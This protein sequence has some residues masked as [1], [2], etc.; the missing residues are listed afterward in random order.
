[1]TNFRTLW[2][3]VREAI[4][5]EALSPLLAQ[6]FVNRALSDIYRA[7]NWSFLIDTGFFQCP[8]S[9]TTGTI[10][11]TQFSRVV[12]PNGAAA[13]AWGS[14]GLTIPV[15]QRQIRVGDGPLYSVSEH[16]I[17]GTESWNTNAVAGAV[18]LET[19]YQES[20]AAGSSYEMYRAYHRPPSTDFL[21]LVSVVDRDQNMRLRLH[22]TREELDVRDPQRN[23]SGT[24]ECV[25]TF[26]VDSSGYP[27]FELH[28]HVK[29]AKSFPVTYLKSGAALSDDTDTPYAGIPDEVIIERALYHASLFAHGQKGLKAELKGVDWLGLSQIRDA[30]YQRALQRAKMHDEETYPQNVLSGSRVT[31]RSDEWARTHATF[32]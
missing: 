12:E 26:K 3:E 14:L 18:L 1:M 29:T 27:L 20:T 19:A 4:P 31:S 2:H 16:D 10:T 24:P 5:G 9:V 13:T 25:A 8:V 11:V 6:R 17:A 21:R 22:A 28:P 30:N 7:R 32:Q 15:T 23:E